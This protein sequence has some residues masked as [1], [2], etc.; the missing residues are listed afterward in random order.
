M[1]MEFP[2]S[3]S[4]PAGAERGSDWRRIATPEGVELSVRLAGIGDRFAA[5]LVDLLLLIGTAV[6]LTVLCFVL[7]AA[8]RSSA[9]LAPLA[10]FFT[11]GSSLYFLAFE[12]HWQG[13][14]PGKRWLGLRVID[15]R[16]GALTPQAIVARNLMRSLELFLPTGML[17]AASGGGWGAL[18]LLAWL[19][20]FALMPF[21]NRNRQRCGDMIA[22][23]WVIVLP[24]QALG[25]ELLA[26]SARFVFSHAQLDAY[27][28]RELQVLE[29]LL[30]RGDEPTRSRKKEASATERAAVLADVGLRIRRRIGWT[31]PVAPADEEVFLHD[32]Y[33]AQR[34]HLEF[35]TVTTGRRRRTKNDGSRAASTG[36]AG[37]KSGRSVEH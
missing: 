16:G 36:G 20:I 27:G 8:T 11:L 21:F 4:A 3:G 1:T 15:R 25:I 31:A 17:L 33:S 13:M 26:A 7:W 5:L 35:K 12:L 19:L 30:R 28:E 6:V 10:L 24:K 34:A 18:S 14:T 32:F 2:A 29:D 22:G 37:V 9:M 23:T